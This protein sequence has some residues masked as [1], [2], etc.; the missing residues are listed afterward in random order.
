MRTGNVGLA[1]CCE[2]RH[3][4][5]HRHLPI[6]C[7]L[8]RGQATRGLTHDACPVR[9]AGLQDL[10]AGQP[11]RV[12]GGRWL[13][14]TRQALDGEQVHPPLLGRP[15]P[16]CLPVSLPSAPRYSLERYGVSVRVLCASGLDARTCTS[17]AAGCGQKQRGLPRREA[18]FRF[19]VEVHS[20]VGWCESW[21]VHHETVYE[22]AVYEATAWQADGRPPFECLDLSF[23]IS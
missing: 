4:M 20:A 14:Q 23:R 8:V 1:G 21:L 9:C 2:G 5:A 10:L 19:D 11:S 7:G 12:P 16:R 3:A 6:S 22:A 13:R 15:C 18:S 17:Q